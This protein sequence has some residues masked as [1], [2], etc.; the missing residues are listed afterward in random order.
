MNKKQIMLIGLI[1]AGG[2]VG[3]TIIKCLQQDRTFDSDLIEFKFYTQT[4]NLGTFIPIFNKWIK[5]EKFFMS[6]LQELD[7]DFI[8][9]ATENDVSN[10]II[11]FANTFK[12]KTK[13]IDLSSE[14]RL[15][16][17][18]PLVIPEVNPEDLEFKSN[19]ISSPNCTTTFLVMVLKALESL[20]KIS[21]VYV[22]T[23]Q[24]A[25]GA[26]IKGLEELKQQARDW[27]ENED[28]DRVTQTFWSKPLLFNVFSHNSSFE[29]NLYNSEEMKIIK[30]T[31]KILHR[32]DLKITPTCVRVPV[33]TSHCESINIEFDRPLQKN[34]II[35]KLEKFPGIKI[36]NNCENNTFPE[37]F[38][39]SGLN[40]IFVGR[41]RSDL[42]D[43]RCWNFFV[44]G[45]QLVKGSGL[46]AVQILKEL[47]K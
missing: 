39:S 1:G 29:S 23:Y 38:T 6:N 25:S 15:K 14:F 26:G 7:F 36:V 41:I 35:Q 34:D 17:G 13:F 4:T 8:I 37:P 31:K 24:S 2:L 42:C 46:N 28:L 32:P 47:I 18:I 30:E 21:R 22:S 9:L 12:L 16:D 43:D 44:C 19:V 45:D 10:E 33:L 27:V 40:D 3:Q 11:T 5:I 20:G